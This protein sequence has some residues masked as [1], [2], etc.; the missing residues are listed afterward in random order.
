MLPP[1]SEPVPFPPGGTMTTGAAV[2]F[3]VPES[4]LVTRTVVV[5]GAVTGG[6]VMSTVVLGNTIDVVYVVV[7]D[8]VNVV[9]CRI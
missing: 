7:G 4:T 5:V 8:A 6:T 9:G 3:V 2:T 1:E